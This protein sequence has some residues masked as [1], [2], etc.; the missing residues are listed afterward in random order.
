MHLGKGFV[1]KLPGLAFQLGGIDVTFDTYLYSLGSQPDTGMVLS[2]FGWIDPVLITKG[3]LKLQAAVRSS[4]F[5][6]C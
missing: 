1:L 6:W 4:P 5:V 2:A 3:G